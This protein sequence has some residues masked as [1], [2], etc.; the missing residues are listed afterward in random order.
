MHRKLKEVVASQNRML[1]RLDKQ[2]GDIGDKQMEAILLQQLMRAAQVVAGHGNPLISINYEN[3]IED[4]ENTAKKIAEFL[5]ME[6]DI[7]AMVAAV[8]ASL[9]REKA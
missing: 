6:L 2:G 9:H 1:E 4:P 5:E 7:A 8:D 3:A